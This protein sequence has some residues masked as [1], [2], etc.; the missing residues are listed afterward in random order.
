MAQHSLTQCEHFASGLTS[1]PPPLCGVHP[2]PCAGT[3]NFRASVVKK[4]ELSGP[5]H[6]A[7]AMW[8]SSGEISSALGTLLPHVRTRG[9]IHPANQIQATPSRTTTF[10]RHCAPFLRAVRCVLRGKQQFP[11]FTST[12]TH[13]IIIIIITISRTRKRSS[14]RKPTRI[15]NQAKVSISV[16]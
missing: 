9:T 8:V 10:M 13:T 12:G 4:H 16:S 7:L 14:T 5:H 2:P 11:T 15:V 6:V 3:N 1:N